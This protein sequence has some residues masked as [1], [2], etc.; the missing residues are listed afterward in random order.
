MTP[1]LMFFKS[2]GSNTTFRLVNNRS[3][4]YRQKMQH[5]CNLLLRGLIFATLIH[6]FISLAP[7]TQVLFSIRWFVKSTTLLT[8]LVT[9][10]SAFAQCNLQLTGTVTDADNRSKL[11]GASI[12]ITEI[13]QFATTDSAGRYSIKGICPGS[14][15]L[16]VSHIGCNPVT[17]HIH[18]KD[19]GMQNVQLPHAANN[20]TN[21]TVTGTAIQQTA[22]GSLE[23]RGRAL[24][25]RQGA[26]LGQMLQQVPGVS[27]LQTGTNIYKPVINGLHSNRVLILN[28]GIRQEGQ[29]WGSEHAPEVDPYIANRL[30]VIKGASSLRYGPDAIGGVV[31][32]EPKLL[33]VVP[34]VNAEVNLAGFSNNRQGVVSA[35]IEGNAAKHP[36]FSWRLQGTAKRGG[37]ARTPDYWLANSGLSEYNFSAAAAL[38]TRSKGVEVFLSRF[39]TK[40]GIFTGSH[41]GNS[42]DLINAI[43]NKQPP[44]YIR[45][46]GFTYT[47]GRPYQHI[48]HNLA[49]IKSFIN[50]GETG[51]LN[52][53]LSA[54]YNRRKEYDVKRFQSS[55]DIPQLDIDL[56][57]TGADLVWDHFGGK[58]VRGTVGFTG[59]FQSNNY[60]ERFFIP[61]YNAVSAGVFVIEKYSW[62]KWLL[63]GGLRYDVRSIYSISSNTGRPFPNQDYGSTSANAAATYKVSNY[64][65]FSLNYSSAWRPP[66]I[67]ELYSDGLHHGAA[68]LERG[69][70]TLHP[71]RANSFLLNGA[72]DKGPLRIDVSFYQKQITDFMFLKPVYP[73]QLTIRGAFPSFIY[74]QTNARLRGIDA[75]IDYQFTPHFSAVGKASILRAF[76]KKANDWLIQM[77]ADRYE[78]EVQY[79]FGDGKTWKSN[80]AK[81]T[82]AQ[83]LRQTRT[84]GTGNIEIKQPDGSI[85]L[86]SDYAPPPPAYTLLG[87]EAGTVV[88]IGKLPVSLVAGATNLLNIK[89][90]DYMNAFRYYAD[91]MGRNISLRIKIPLTIK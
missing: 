17:L 57:T 42:T 45:N 53:V 74:S 44:D 73:P 67:N 36:S 12:Y 61:N 14:Y 29:Q 54:Q 38:H 40:L 48:E 43:N 46:A 39:N 35:M 79:S 34:G 80:Y 1:E 85:S 68:R 27:V 91:D 15:N 41:I 10:G 23:L 33:P 31:L 20:L 78:G 83:V 37:N 56:I 30:I 47:I 72:Y 7:L 86:Q 8:A 28:N 90:R 81:A 59:S 60:Y 25:A 71:E 3:S 50:T 49:K 63:E 70:S 84:P 16:T 22:T 65:K 52:L 24:D 82:V 62:D 69:D 21:V 75:S 89:Y 32:V 5:C 6:N 2:G 87:V 9:A 64:L 55:A 58:R 88:T 13:K 18:L 66:Q 51:R 19:D 77:P 4:I 26:S 76:D 11:S